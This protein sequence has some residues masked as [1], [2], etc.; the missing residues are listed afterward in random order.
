MTNVS[1]N[2]II[3][4]WLQREPEHVISTEPF[5]L[6]NGCFSLDT[7]S[8]KHMNTTPLENTDYS[9]KARLSPSILIPL[10]PK[11]EQ[12]NIK[13]LYL[14]DQPSLDFGSQYHEPPCHELCYRSLFLPS[15]PDTTR[16][17]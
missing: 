10:R 1:I 7:R 9:L 13:E 16:P 14:L 17:S 3:A 15:R 6:W 12:V 5:H 11:H 4:T 2:S 8:H